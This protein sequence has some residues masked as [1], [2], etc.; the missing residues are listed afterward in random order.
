MRGDLV[1]KL[2]ARCLSTGLAVLA[3]VVLAL[4]DATGWG[5]A[6]AVAAVVASAVEQ[7]V[8][9]GAD[10]VA[11]TTLIAAAVLVGYWRRLDDGVDLA[12]VATALVLLGLVLLVGPLRTAGNLEM[13]TGNLP[14][15]TWTP[16]VADQ[17][18]TALL[19]LLAVVALA[20]AL[21]VPAVVPL[22]ASLL[23]GAGVGAV[24]RRSTRSASTAP[25]RH[26]CGPTWGPR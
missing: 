4:T 16:L 5:L 13:R 19:G 11:E 6:L 10:L 17:L 25:W 21:T 2:A 23:V 26:R 3:F 22:V 18:G 24:A 7:R 20:A 1:R 9:P 15:R 12:L 14:V 8:R